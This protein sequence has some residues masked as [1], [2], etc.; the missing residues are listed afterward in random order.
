M[1]N[2]FTTYTTYCPLSSEYEISCGTSVSEGSTYVYT[3]GYKY[4]LEL[5]TIY[6]TYFPLS[7]PTTIIESP[8]GGIVHIYTTGYNIV[9][10][11]AKTYTT[12]CSTEVPTT[13][14]EPT[15]A[16]DTSYVSWT[17]APT[18]AAESNSGSTVNESHESGVIFVHEG[19][20]SG[21]RFSLL[22]GLISFIGAL[23]RFK[24]LSNFVTFYL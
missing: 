23:F 18:V 4:F 22:A 24:L 15:A 8:E 5:K 16:G 3:S 7:V 2:D 9:T 20:G 21:L 1:T 19:S 10:K 17:P 6:T 14:T 11:G 12:Y 13:I